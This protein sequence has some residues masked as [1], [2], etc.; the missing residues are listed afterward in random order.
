MSSPLK[1]ATHLAPKKTEFGRR[2][3]EHKLFKKI[4]K[5][6]NITQ[7]L[8]FEHLEEILNVKKLKVPLPH[9]RDRHCF[10]IK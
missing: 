4:Q 2:K 3:P 6:F 8:L 7:K 1:A 10:M 9:G 5:S